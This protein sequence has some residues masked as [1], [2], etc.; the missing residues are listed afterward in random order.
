MYVATQSFTYDD[1]T[2]RKGQKLPEEISE[3]LAQALLADGVVE[4]KKEKSSKAKAPETE[5]SREDETL[6][7]PEEEPAPT[8]AEPTAASEPPD[9]LG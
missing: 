9:A 2:I 3:E 6:E 5:P 4:V 7:V 1:K 8:D